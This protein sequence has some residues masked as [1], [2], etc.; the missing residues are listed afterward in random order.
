MEKYTKEQKAAIL[1]AK[2]KIA[3]ANNFYEFHKGIID[4][5]LYLNREA[6]DAS[7]E[8]MMINI[9]IRDQEWDTPF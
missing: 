8:I 2:E 4:Q 3:K 6:D 5:Y 7:T 1:L 9:K